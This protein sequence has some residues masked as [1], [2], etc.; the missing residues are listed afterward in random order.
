MLRNR[1]TINKV[2]FVA[3]IILILSMLILTFG[4]GLGL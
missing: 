1:K 3:A 2:M 4:P